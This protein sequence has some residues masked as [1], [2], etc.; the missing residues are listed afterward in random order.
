MLN[1]TRM[2][3]RFAALVALLCLQGCASLPRA[4]P[5]S[6]S[7]ALVDTG[8]TPLAR[9]VAASTPQAQRAQ[10]GFR[11]LPTG[12]FAFDARIVLAWRAVRSIDAQYYQVHSDAVGHRFL[13]ELR[14]AVARGVRVRLLSRFVTED[15]L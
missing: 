14:D 10:S 1:A 9:A 6:P 11:I 13:R 8:D 7:T 2:F 5:R 3:A 12:D 15:L 4:V